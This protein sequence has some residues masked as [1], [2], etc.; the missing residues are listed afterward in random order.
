MVIPLLM[1]GSFLC[2]AA[3][4]CGDILGKVLEPGRRSGETL[5][6][7]R[8]VSTDIS[9]L[10][11]LDSE[12]QLSQLLLGTGFTVFLHESSNELLDFVV[13]SFGAEVSLGLVVWTS[14]QTVCVSIPL[15]RS[16]LDVEVGQIG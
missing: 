12:P 4:S 15:A 3:Q 9:E 1:V 13:F 14:G 10:E 8:R 16:V 5:D 7:N 11:D 6:S 2:F